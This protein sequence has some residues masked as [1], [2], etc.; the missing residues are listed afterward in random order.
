MILLLKE[1]MKKKKEEINEIKNYKI[2]DNIIENIFEY[3]NNK[4]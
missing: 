3:L 1:K 2:Q 4:N